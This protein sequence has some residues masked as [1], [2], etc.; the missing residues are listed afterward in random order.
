[1]LTG[2]VPWPAEFAERYRQAGYWQDDTFAGLLR[3]PARSAGDRTAVVTRGARLSYAEL[4]LRADRLAAGLRALGVRPGDRIVV[5]LPNSVE[6]LV[7]CVALFRVG[8]I[9]VLALAAHRRAE[10]GY[11]CE[12]TEAAG[13]VIPDIYVGY[14]HRELAR[15]VRAGVPGLRH[16]LVAGDPAEF[17]GLADVTGPPAELAPPDP[18][19]VALCL[20][21]GGTTGLPKLIPRT[22]RDYLYQAR[23][24]ARAMSFGEDSAYLAALPIVHNAALGCPGA[25]GALD[26]GAKVVVAGSPAPDE[27]FELIARENV[28]LTTL[29]PVFLPLWAAT[30]G[31]YGTDLSRLVIEVG[32]ARLDPEVARECEEA[33]GCTITR[34]FGMA[35]G[36][37][38]FTR[39]TDPASTRL[40]TEGR[41]LSAADELRVV[42]PDGQDVLAGEVGELLARGPCLLRGYYLAPDYNAGAFTPDGF[43]RTGDL[44]RITREGNLIVEG[45][46]KDVVNRGGEKVPAA[47]VEDHLRGHPKVKDVA[48]TGVPDGSLG[49]R[50]CA[51]VIPAAS[52]P[53]LRELRDFLTGRG[54]AGYKL[55]DQLE[56]VAAFPHTPVGKVDKAALR[57]GLA[58]PVQG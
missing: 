30:R 40:Q 56:L 14:D 55:P 17:T 12:H 57:S 26:A 18:G 5:Q 22:H 7:L 54:L 10:I 37:L 32:G 8:A 24:T 46:I 51:F 58:R 1:V 20:L 35:E 4:D 28:T 23:A 43:L 42:R 29:M 36:L 11:L 52:P 50:S 34:W 33:L 25:L 53:A 27:V 47:E 3:G 6:L 41:P 9:P 2:T 49:E 39:V 31:L 19:E 44:A 45:R 15:E 16:V 21:S 48:V 13:L 38:C